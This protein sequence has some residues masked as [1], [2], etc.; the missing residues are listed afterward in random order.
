MRNVQSIAGAEVL[1]VC[2]K[3]SA[4]RHRI[5]RAFPGIY[6]T[7]D[8]SEVRARPNAVAVVTPVWTHFELAKAALV[9]PSGKTTAS[10]DGAK[11]P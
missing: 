7:A 8:A 1:S 11:T 3:S 2:D 5:H 6:V 10:N 4:A 9:Y